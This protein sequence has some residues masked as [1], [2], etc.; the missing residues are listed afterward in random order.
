MLCLL[1][2]ESTKLVWQKKY[3]CVCVFKLCAFLNCIFA[4]HMFYILNPNY[5]NPTKTATL[6][7]AAQTQFYK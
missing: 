6:T 2:C 7:H 4:V 5:N 1:Q 3:L